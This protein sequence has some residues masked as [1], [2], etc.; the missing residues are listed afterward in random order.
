MQLI[1]YLD[2]PYVRRVAVTLRFLGID[3]EH[4]ELSIWRDFDE[5][6]ALSPLVKVPTLVCDDGAV[7]V[8]S[9]LI[10]EF[11]E[12]HA[13]G[14][15]RLMPASAVAHRDALQYI[16]TALVG[17]EKAVQLIYELGHRPPALQ[18]QP[19]VARLRTQLDGA[20]RLMEA[21]VSAAALA[22]DEWLVGAD[23]S[24]A[25]IT[26]A[27]AWRF[28]RDSRH[29]GIEAGAFP[30]LAAHSARA[31]ALPEFLACPPG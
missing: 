2:S 10:I 22:G 31:E 25:D 11:L 29:A 20:L 13:A 16:G 15:R 26:T 18:H 6:R 8:D 1:G 23:L 3:F 21:A 28:A 27:V 14:G 24:Q 5:F 30:A 9:T 7:L 4:R 19:W 12:R 17:M